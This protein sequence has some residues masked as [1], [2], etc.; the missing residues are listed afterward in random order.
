VMRCDKAARVKF[1]ADRIKN[2]WDCEHCGM[3]NVACCDECDVCYS[4]RVEID[5]YDP[6]LAQEI[7]D[8][9][10]DDYPDLWKI[11]INGSPYL[12]TYVA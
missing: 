4:P 5:T 1:P 6:E 2:G 8:V 12:Q 7:Q 9:Y 11:D 10:H 3:L